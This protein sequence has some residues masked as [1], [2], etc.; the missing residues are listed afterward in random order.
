MTRSTTTCATWIAGTSGS[1]SR[2]PASNIKEYGSAVWNHWLAKRYG[3]SIVRSAWA[4]GRRPRV[5]SY[6]AA[7]RDAGPSDFTLDFSRFARDL[8]EWRTDTAFPEGSLYPD[9]E[10]PGD[11]ADQR[12]HA[13]PG[14]R[15]YDLPTAARPA[16]RREEPAGR[17]RG[18]PRDRDG[19]RGGRPDRGS[20]RRDRGLRPGAEATPRDDAVQIARPGRF[21]RITVVLVNADAKVNGF[22]STDWRYTGNDDRVA[23]RAK[24]IR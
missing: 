9:V 13:L 5:R 11:P 10:A 19:A 23:V 15:P 18:P 8:A 1:R 21:D 4:Q 22:G 14:P 6:D 2:S 12:G 17:G 24:L 20:D 16:R 7:I 3:P